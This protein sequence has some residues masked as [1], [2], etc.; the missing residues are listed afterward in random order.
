VYRCSWFLSELNCFV[1]QLVVLRVSPLC[2]WV[3]ARLLLNK[4]DLVERRCT[5]WR[6]WQGALVSLVC[7]VQ[8][9]FAVVW[10]H[11]QEFFFFFWDT[12]LAS[13]DSGYVLTAIKQTKDA[14]QNMSSSLKSLQDAATQLNTN[15]SSVRNSI[16]NSL[17][18]SDCTS[19]PASKICD[20]IRPS[21]SSLGSSLNSSQVSGREHVT[22]RRT[23]GGSS[24]L[25]LGAPAG[26]TV[27]WDGKE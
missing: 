22:A 1:D 17:S 16:E 10:T 12:L 27:A 24:G 25:R 2:S 4:W 14:L 18:S 8:L 7:P 26:C 9:S 20:S 11:L 5:G 6:G 13:S 19:D 23:R 3:C 21:L 15:L